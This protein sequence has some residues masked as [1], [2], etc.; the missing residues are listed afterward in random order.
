MLQHF[1]H[2]LDSVARGN[3][4]DE[5]IHDPSVINVLAALQRV[6]QVQERITVNLRAI[7]KIPSVKLG[8]AKVWQGS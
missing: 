5:K 1:A 3:L 4:V 2:R 6:W 7:K 8:I